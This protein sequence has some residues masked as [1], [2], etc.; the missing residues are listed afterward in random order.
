MARV[1]N[2]EVYSSLPELLKI[3]GATLR[4]LRT[5]FI[6]MKST[7]YKGL[8]IGFFYEQKSSN[9]GKILDRLGVDRASSST[10]DHPD[11]T[12]VMLVPQDKATLEGLPQTASVPLPRDH[13]NINEFTQDDADFDVIALWL[14]T[15]IPSSMRSVISQENYDAQS[16][17]SSL[18]Q[19]LRS[20][21]KTLPLSAPSSN[22]HSR[23]AYQP[24]KRQF[25]CCDTDWLPKWS[26][27]LYL[28]YIEL[29][30][31]IYYAGVTYFVIV[32]YDALPL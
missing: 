28:S 30:L 9:V 19:Q 17:R 3:N 14:N 1:K 8:S 5:Q 20:P 23:T 21:S 27:M 18:Y 13:F 2:K 12:Q 24:G 22:H 26:I 4:E 32:S 6:G 29:Q 10:G 31:L 16:P 7:D 11:S 25:T 15:C